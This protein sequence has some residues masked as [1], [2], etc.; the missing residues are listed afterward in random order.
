[1]TAI[2]IQLPA[3]QASYAT[4][5]SVAR[6]ANCSQEGVPGRRRKRSAE[7]DQHDNEDEEDDDDASPETVATGSSSAT[8][9]GGSEQ[10]WCCGRCGGCGFRTV[11][12]AGLLGRRRSTPP[13]VNATVLC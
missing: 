10:W 13:F 5:A 7:E 9:E 8:D 11:I 6:A 1:M 3:C 2:V 4:A 12:P